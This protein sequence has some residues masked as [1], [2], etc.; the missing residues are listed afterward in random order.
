MANLVFASDYRFS[1]TLQANDIGWFLDLTR[2]SLHGPSLFS[3]EMSNQEIGVAYKLRNRRRVIMTDQYATPPAVRESYPNLVIDEGQPYTEITVV[4]TFIFGTRSVYA[5]LTIRNNS[6]LQQTLDVFPYTRINYSPDQVNRLGLHPAQYPSGLN[7]PGGVGLE[8]NPVRQAGSG[9]STVLMLKNAGRDKFQVSEFLAF[10]TALDRQSLVNT[11]ITRARPF[12]YASMQQTVTLAAGQEQDLEFL[13]HIDA[14]LATAAHDAQSLLANYN[15]AATLA[16]VRQANEQIVKANTGNADLD[17]LFSLRN[18]LLLQTVV[19]PEGDLAHLSFIFKRGSTREP[20]WT[21]KGQHAHESISFLSLLPSNPEVLRDVL[22]NFFD[23]QQP[24]GLVP[25]KI[26]RDPDVTSRM[27]QNQIATLPV[28][29]YLAWQYYRYTNDLE[30]LRQAYPHLKSFNEY[31]RAHRDVNGNG[32]YEWYGRGPLPNGGELEAVRD[33]ANVVGQ[34][35]H[36][37]YPA[38]SF[39]DLEAPDLQGFIYR[40]LVTLAKISQALEL[41][42]D[43]QAFTAAAEALKT[44]TLAQLWDD[45]RSTFFYKF[46]DDRLNSATLRPVQDYGTLVPLWAGMLTQEQ[47]DRFIRSHLLNPDEFWR[48]HGIPSLAANTPQ[49]PGASAYNPKGRSS[50]WNGPVWGPWN[51]M[52]LEA[53]LRYGYADQALE[54]LQRFNAAQKTMMTT[55]GH[56]YECHGPDDLAANACQQD[57]NFASAMNFGYYL[58]KQAGAAQFQFTRPIPETAEWVKG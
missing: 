35:A 47:A 43:S 26:S 8:G 14:D 7:L 41:P 12:V 38:S 57:Y 30:F 16:S 44:L 22:L 33:G 9:A 13:V 46:A 29:A 17:E 18:D 48:P 6:T 20:A 24:D 23:K 56:L 34:L 55:D 39:R 52:A 51:L 11:L 40:D 4:R 5:H 58:L 2:Q 31:L 53:L 37:A 19:R 25:Y 1:L 42:D 45:A 21:Q 10:S 36:L 28:L 27:V 32:L 54:L 15:Y 3:A 49:Y 50:N